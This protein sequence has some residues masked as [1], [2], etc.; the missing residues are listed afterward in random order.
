MMRP[1]FV[2]PDC[3][4][5]SVQEDSTCVA[6]GADTTVTDMEDDSAPLTSATER[7]RLA[8]DAAAQWREQ[9]AAALVEIG[10]LT[11][12]RNRWRDAII[13]ASVVNWTYTHEH[14]D[15]PRKAIN[16]LQSCMMREA[17]DPLCSQIAHDLHQK[18][19]DLTEE[20][21]HERN[22]KETVADSFKSYARWSEERLDK[23][24][25]EH[26]DCVKQATHAFAVRHAEQLTMEK[27]YL[28]EDLK[29]ARAARVLACLG[30]EGLGVVRNYT[31]T[32][33]WYTKAH[34]TLCNG[35]GYQS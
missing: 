22:E 33:G 12:D 21:A 30:C 20:L 4:P 29:A 28:T 3:G 1:R 23:L 13:D 27:S 25:A 35:T 14:D 8:E 7:A 5:V 15:N 34:C 32:V 10:R 26:T 9:L 24:R 6:C 16:D 18:I 17:L 2:C 31:G 19:A 11:E